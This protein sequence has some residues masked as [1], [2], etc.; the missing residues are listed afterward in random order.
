[1]K[2]LRMAVAAV[3]A[4]TMV[5]TAGTDPGRAQG[6][7]AGT[8]PG[9]GAPGRR[10]PESPVGG[11][12]GAA[13]PGVRTADISAETFLARSRAAHRFEIEAAEIALQ[14][15]SDADVAYFA[16]HLIRDHR[17]ALDR[18]NATTERAGLAMPRGDLDEADRQKLQKLR[19]ANAGEFDLTYMRMQHDT[20]REAHLLHADFASQGQPA[21]LRETAADIARI[22]EE[23][24]ARAR[25]VE[26]M[27]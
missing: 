9:L 19:Q 12:P 23:N 1:M 16:R 13:G 8:E 22:V 25:E 18:L 24:M 11:A 14:R 10:A 5:S 3:A 20:L 27:I 2:T 15:A 7:G 26:T 6:P 21:A 17:T 4:I